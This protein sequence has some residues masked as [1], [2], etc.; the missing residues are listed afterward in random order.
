MGGRKDDL[1]ADALSDLNRTPKKSCSLW[2][3]PG[4]VCQPPIHHRKYDRDGVDGFGGFLKNVS[5]LFLR[6]IKVLFEQPRTGLFIKYSKL[7]IL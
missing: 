1:E 6:Q 3:G 5:S 2:M 4:V 7:Y